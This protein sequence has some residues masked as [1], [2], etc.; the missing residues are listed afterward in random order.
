MNDAVK[1]LSPD[2]A[3]ADFA[4][5]VRGLAPHPLADKD[6]MMTDDELEGLKASISRGYDAAKPIKLF[7]GRIL[8]GRNRRAAGLAIGH[9]FIPANFVEFNGT[10]AEAE[11]YVD[12]EN[13]HRRHLTTDDK[14]K[15]VQ[16]MLEEHPEWSN[17]KIG[18]LCGVSHTTVG[19]QRQE[20]EDDDKDYKKFAKDWQNLSDKHRERLPHPLF[21]PV[22]NPNLLLDRRRSLRPF[23]KA[24]FQASTRPFAKGGN[25]DSAKHRC[26]DRRMLWLHQDAWSGVGKSDSR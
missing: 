25:D 11:R 22:P 19:N 13:L 14:K 15:R 16:K 24:P 23:A 7:E 12:A 18:S 10:Y 2:T 21:V 3:A 17:R 20:E 26:A 9:H 6:R 1:K 8:D 5:W 4:A